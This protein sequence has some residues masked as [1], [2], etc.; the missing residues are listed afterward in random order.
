MWSNLKGR[1]RK[2]NARAS[3]SGVADHKGVLLSKLHS[4]GSRCRL[5]LVLLSAC[6]PR[7]NSESDTNASRA[8]PQP[9]PRIQAS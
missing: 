3:G 6:S 9:S 4:I 2:H 7:P 1:S 5:H 8:G